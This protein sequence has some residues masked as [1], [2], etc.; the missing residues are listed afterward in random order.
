MA[1]YVNNT[2]SA[3]TFPSLTDADGNVLVAEAGATFEA[4][5][6]LIVDGISSAPAKKGKA[7]EAAPV[8]DDA[9][10]GEDA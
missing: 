4:P 5:D 3:V 10:A 1:I 6:G 8:V 7:P 9:P 2:A